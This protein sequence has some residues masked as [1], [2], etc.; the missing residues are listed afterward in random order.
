MPID[1]VKTI[2]Q[3]EGKQGVGMLRAKYRIGGVPVF[4]QG[5]I[6]A[7]SATFVGE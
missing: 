3:V 2:M 1:T 6:A 7:S 4:F 5:A